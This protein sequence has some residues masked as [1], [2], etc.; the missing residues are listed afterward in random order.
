MTIEDVLEEMWL[1]FAG[2]LP[3]SSAAPGDV[4]RWS[5]ETSLTKLSLFDEIAAK[6]A[7]GFHERSLAFDLCDAIV[8]AMIEHVYSG[9]LDDGGPRW[10]EVFLESVPGL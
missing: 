8:N 3:E 4:Q 2:E 1:R 6:L 5:Q 9:F 10:P 7:T